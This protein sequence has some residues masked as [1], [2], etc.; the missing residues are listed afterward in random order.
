[1]DM[2][3]KQRVTLD[4]VFATPTRADIPWTDIES[5]AAAVGATVRQ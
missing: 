4:K 5:M 3:S 1:M 2:N